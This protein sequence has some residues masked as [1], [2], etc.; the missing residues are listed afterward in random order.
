MMLVDVEMAFLHGNVQEEV[1][2]KESE[3]L[4]KGDDEC[5]LLNKSMCGLDQ[6]ARQ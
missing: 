3:G 2:M 4:G 1:C 6:A 5:V